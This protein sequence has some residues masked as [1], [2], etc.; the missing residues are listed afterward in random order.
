MSKSPTLSEVIRS[1]IAAALESVHVSMPGSVVRYDATKR[2]AD[3]QPLIKLAYEDENGDRVAASLPVIVNCPVQF[4]KGGGLTITLPVENGDI[5]IL[6]FSEASLDKWLSGKGKEVDP[7][8][9]LRFGLADAFFIPG[10]T[11]SGSP[12]NTPAGVIAIGRSGNSFEKAV[13]GNSLMTLLH[14][15]ASAIPYT[16]PPSQEAAALSDDVEVT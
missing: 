7:E 15:M 4:S 8:I 12:T 5:G 16:I 1:G 6:V 13:K 3:V 14:S 10:I 2:Q 11:T 9:D